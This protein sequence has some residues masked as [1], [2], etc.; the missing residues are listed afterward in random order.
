MKPV[1]FIFLLISCMHASA[2]SI[3]ELKD[4]SIYFTGWGGQTDRA[5]VMRKSDSTLLT[6]GQYKTVA[7]DRYR[8]FA[9]NDSG[10]LHGSFKDFYTASDYR[11]KIYDKGLLI[12]EYYKLGNRLVSE[13]FD[14]T[15]SV[16]LYNSTQN[17]WEPQLKSVNVEKEYDMHGNIST[18]RYLKGPY[19]AY[20]V[21]R[22]KQGILIME[23]TPF[24]QEKE[25]DPSGKVYRLVQYNWTLKQIE[26]SEFEK[27]IL[28]KKTILKNSAA[29]W[30]PNGIV[31][32]NDIGLRDEVMVYHYSDGKKI[33]K[34]E[35]IKNRKRTVT[36]YN[37]QGKVISVN[38][39]PLP[40]TLTASGV[41]PAE[42]K[43]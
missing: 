31:Q 18:C 16:L 7:G 40:K 2:Q 5:R 4:S 13:S 11:E 12:R 9:V 3:T 37:L 36:E 8:V 33:S 17:R 42:T 38:T 15:V 29:S 6:T 26:T 28:K 25:M 32:F 24:Y 30:D 34:T 23:K 35:L 41:A 21:F 19:Y 39:Y 1:L 20:T 22:Y 43:Q 10:Y 14:S 27:G